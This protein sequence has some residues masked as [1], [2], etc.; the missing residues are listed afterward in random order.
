MEVLPM[1]IMHVGIFNKYLE[2]FYQT[3]ENF[4]FHVT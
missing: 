1:F 4:M 2:M 3:V